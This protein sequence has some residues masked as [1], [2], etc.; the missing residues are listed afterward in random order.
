[1]EV[2]IP[3]TFFF[4]RLTLYFFDG[5][6]VRARAALL[7]LWPIFLPLTGRKAAGSFSY[8]DW[9][10]LIFFFHHGSPFPTGCD[11]FAFIPLLSSVS[12][13]LLG[14]AGSRGFAAQIILFPI[15][16]FSFR[17]LEKGLV[18]GFDY[19]V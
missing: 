14:W 5:R 10:F 2:M 17:F 19:C 16:L 3:N 12:G 9:T 4:F 7:F 13:L 6:Q 8:R 18:E 1:M 11:F 15:P